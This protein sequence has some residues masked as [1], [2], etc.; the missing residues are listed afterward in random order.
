MAIKIAKLTP[1]PLA[2]S[3]R[4]LNHLPHPFTPRLALHARVLHLHPLRL[5]RRQ[6]ASQL[7]AH[8]GQLVSA[9]SQRLLLPQRHRACVLM[10]QV[11]HSC[12]Q[13]G[14]LAELLFAACVELEAVSV[15]L[16]LGPDQLSL[17]LLAALLGL[18][19][20]ADGS[21]LA[22]LKHD[23]LAVELARLNA[24]V[25]VNGAGGGM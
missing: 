16:L 2:G 7:R 14:H 9:S 3:C 22:D 19:K 18:V 13:I 11:L 24:R 5:R 1:A 21:G 25:R 4:P 17:E 12:A 20:L 6:L 23:D 8:L 10:P 15:V